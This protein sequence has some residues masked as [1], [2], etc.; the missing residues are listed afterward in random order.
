MQT[1]KIEENLHHMQS[2]GKLGS[3]PPYTREQHR[4]P[5]LKRSKCAHKSNYNEFK[6]CFN[7]IVVGHEPSSENPHVH[8]STVG[9]MN[10]IQCAPGNVRGKRPRQNP[11][12][13]SPFGETARLFFHQ[14][15]GLRAPKSKNTPFLILIWGGILVW[16]SNLSHFGYLRIL[17][18]S[19]ARSGPPRVG[20]LNSVQK[21]K[22]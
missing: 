7:R 8:P 13:L 3:A 12:R 18:G 20:R 11:K 1:R 22:P 16:P 17:V 21:P 10:S 2:A 6:G 4:H 19:H 14:S 9:H 15:V 5:L